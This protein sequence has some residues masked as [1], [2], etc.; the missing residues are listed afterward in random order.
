MP[1]CTTAVLPTAV[2]GLCLE[3]VSPRLRNNADLSKSSRWCR[4]FCLGKRRGAVSRLIAP[5]LPVESVS[6][7]TEQL[8]LPVPNMHR[9]LAAMLATLLLVTSCV[10]GCSAGEVRRS[11]A[12]VPRTFPTC[13]QHAD[14]CS[15]AAQLLLCSVGP[16]RRPSSC[17]LSISRTAASRLCPLLR[18]LPSS[19]SSARSVGH[20]PAHA[21]AYAAVTM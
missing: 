5:V 3:L 21:H 1:F 13:T 7:L 16:M 10:G 2:S 12:Q 8:A 20:H 19:E 14:C 4:Y 17:L 6:G 9:Q 18:D 11:P 15:V